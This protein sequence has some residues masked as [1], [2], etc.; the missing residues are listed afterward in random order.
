VNI[1]GDVVI[2]GF[3]LADL[4]GVATEPIIGTTVSICPACGQGLVFTGVQKLLSPP[5][6]VMVCERCRLKYWKKTTR[7]MVLLK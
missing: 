1:A 2:H 5:L 4:F 6:D 3:A 7:D